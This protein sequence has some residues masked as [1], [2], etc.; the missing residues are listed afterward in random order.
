[1]GDIVDIVAKT[2]GLAGLVILA[3]FVLIGRDL[4]AL[5]KQNNEI[6]AKMADDKAE[7]LIGMEKTKNCILKL[8]YEE[9]I[10]TNRRKRQQ[11][12]V[13]EDKRDG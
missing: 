10:L 6:L 1:M 12:L 2:G 13:S 5:S 9:G 11:T 4:R 3:L 7:M 8:F